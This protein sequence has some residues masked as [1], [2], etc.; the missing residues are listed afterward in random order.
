MRVSSLA[1]ALL[2]L[3]ACGDET[4]DLREDAA[5]SDNVGHCAYTA[6]ALDAADTEALG[7]AAQG[8]LDAVAGERSTSLRWD[9]TQEETT[10]AFALTPDAGSLTLH[11]GA[12]V[13]PE[14]G[15]AE[16]VDAETACPPYADFA[17]TLRFTTADLRLDETLEV[18]VGVDGPAQGHLV[19]TF[20][21]ADLVGSGPPLEIVPAEWDSV[22]YEITANVGAESLNGELAVYADRQVETEEYQSD[23]GY[24]ND[25]G[26]WPVPE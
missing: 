18:R 3:A 11:A 24:A 21:H 13:P 19:H 20:S 9:L 10:L 4:S 22:N 26:R 2:A 25:V 6:S 15:D 17:A 14:G 23:E 8:A 16:P 12:W 5:I 1:L 7:F